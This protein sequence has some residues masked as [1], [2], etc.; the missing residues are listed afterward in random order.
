MK[1]PMPPLALPKR[2][3]MEKAKLLWEKLGLPPLKPEVPWFGYSL[4]DW[5]DEW[6]RNAADAAAGT[7]MERS[8]S[9]SQRRRRDVLPNT[10]TRAVDSTE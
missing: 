5:T 3:Y 8:E 9:Y 6:D 2:E 10:P 4:G 1:T 7:W